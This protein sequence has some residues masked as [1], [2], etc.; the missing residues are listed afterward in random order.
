ME[1]HIDT[2][3]MRRYKENIKGCRE[4]LFQS[5]AINFPPFE[6]EPTGFCF[7]Q[8]KHACK[9]EPSPRVGIN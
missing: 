4:F 3:D 9:F 7:R 1:I 8:V 2:R 5:I 6:C